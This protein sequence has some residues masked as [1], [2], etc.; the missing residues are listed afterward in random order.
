[1]LFGVLAVAACAQCLIMFLFY[2]KLAQPKPVKE[3]SN[4]DE[5]V[6]GFLVLRTTSSSQHHNAAALSHCFQHR[7]RIFKVQIFFFI[8]VG[9]LGGQALAVPRAL[10]RLLSK[11]GLRP[12]RHRIHP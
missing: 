5:E 2:K 3:C 12:E 1:M 8:T 6:R 10:T 4:V 11:V 7:G 9:V